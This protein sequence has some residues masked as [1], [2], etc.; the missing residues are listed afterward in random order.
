MATAAGVA[1]PLSG[2]DITDD[3][4]FIAAVFDRCTP[5]FHYL[6]REAERLGEKRCLGPAGTWLVGETIRAAL[7]AEGADSFLKAPQRWRPPLREGAVF[8]MSQLL[9]ASGC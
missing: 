9:R 7:L 1:V 3:P 5:L 6:L 4:R 8:S 2:A